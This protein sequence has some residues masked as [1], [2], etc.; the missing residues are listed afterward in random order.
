VSD[1]AFSATFLRKGEKSFF[2][3]SGTDTLRAPNT[4]PF[5]IE[6]ENDGIQ[7]Q[8][9]TLIGIIQTKCEGLGL[10]AER[11]SSHS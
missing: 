4:R 9:I 11:R 5:K 7:L 8:W 2:R 6:K 10:T 3:L 1:A